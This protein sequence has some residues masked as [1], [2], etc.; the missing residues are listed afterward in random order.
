MFYDNVYSRC[1]VKHFLARTFIVSRETLVPKIKGSIQKQNS[2][3]NK[4]S[5]T[6][7]YGN[8]Y[9]IWYSITPEEY[10]I[11]RERRMMNLQHISEQH[12]LSVS[13]CPIC[14]FSVSKVNQYFALSLK[15]K[16]ARIGKHDPAFFKCCNYGT[17]TLT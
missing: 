11:K 4:I 8:A 9:F 3:K 1:I 7:R 13:K 17:A 5:A 6:V 15:N 10:Q 16:N 12:I 14:L 2:C